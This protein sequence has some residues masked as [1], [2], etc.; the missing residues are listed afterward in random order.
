MR[1][2]IQ[3]LFEEVLT[4]EMSDAVFSEHFAR[5]PHF[6]AYIMETISPDKILELLRKYW[7]RYSQAVGQYRYLDVSR[8]KEDLP[9]PFIRKLKQIGV[10][11]RAKSYTDAPS[12]YAMGNRVCVSHH[13]L[14]R[15]DELWGDSSEH[16]IN[17]QRLAVLYLHS[18]GTITDEQLQEVWKKSDSEIDEYAKLWFDDDKVQG[19]R[20]RLIGWTN[21]GKLKRI[22]RNKY[23]VNKEHV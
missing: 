8:V 18:Q 10:I 11:R 23:V 16:Y 20:C 14:N 9:L 1:E 22:A 5:S 6:R 7:E 13:M 12:R 21:A 19:I 15:L 4:K 3:Q 17:W 2:D